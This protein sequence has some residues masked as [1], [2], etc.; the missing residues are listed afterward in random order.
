MLSRDTDAEPPPRR[1]TSRAVANAQLRHHE[2]SED[3]R[4]RWQLL[5]T[6]SLARRTAPAECWESAAV[7][8]SL[9]VELERAMAAASG[10]TPNT[11]SLE[12]PQAECTARAER[13]RASR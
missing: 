6:S 9:R 3:H 7:L 2:H 12:R 4:E 5:D 1:S 11:S 8:R 13:L 10:R